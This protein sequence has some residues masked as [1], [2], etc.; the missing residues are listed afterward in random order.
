MILSCVASSDRGR[1]PG[2]RFPVGRASQESAL[3]A[4]KCRPT[5]SLM[6]MYRE[7]PRG[8]KVYAKL[9]HKRP[10]V[11]KQ[12]TVN[13]A[14]IEL[15]LCTRPPGTRNWA[16]CNRGPPRR[17]PID[18]RRG[19]AGALLATIKDAGDLAELYPIKHSVC[20]RFLRVQ[21]ARSAV[22]ERFACARC[23]YERSGTNAFCRGLE[24]FARPESCQLGSSSWVRALLCTRQFFYSEPIK[25]R[26][27]SYKHALYQAFGKQQRLAIS[28]RFQFTFRRTQALTIRGDYTG[29]HY[30]PLR[31]P[32]TRTAC[33][34][35]ERGPPPP[36]HSND[37]Q[38][39]KLRSS[40]VYLSSNVN[41]ALLESRARIS[42]LQREGA[43][44]RRHW[45]I[46]V[47]PGAPRIALDKPLPTYCASPDS[48][49]NAL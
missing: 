10:D 22:G 1:D 36:F 21:Y 4:D 15:N 20:L 25:N 35:G 33:H 6:N 45:L 32:S 17:V 24:A 40:D 13:M 38:P 7:P 44:G 23:S 31:I 42:R 3:P 28:R 30:W 9:N 27:T 2:I 5:F 41:R 26:G 12:G 37:A 48:P 39:R 18:R 11:L 8:C 47:A 16:E 19:A 29:R 34:G 49:H 46:I 14:R 43:R